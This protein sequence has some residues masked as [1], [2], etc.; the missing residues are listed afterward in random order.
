MLFCNLKDKNSDVPCSCTELASS[1]FD[2]F[3][4][5]DFSSLCDCVSVICDCGT[6][7]VFGIYVSSD[8]LNL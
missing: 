7:H 5:S 2:I 8:I 3:T 1:L 4:I 6:F